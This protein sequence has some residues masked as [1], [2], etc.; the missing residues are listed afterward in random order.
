MESIQPSGSQVDDSSSETFRKAETSDPAMLAKREFQ[1][2]IIDKEMEE[3]VTDQLHTSISIYGKDGVFQTFEQ[4]FKEAHENPDWFALLHNS[5]SNALSA[6]YFACQLKPGDEVIFPVY[7]FHA[8]CSSAMHFGIRPVLADVAE[9]GNIS[10]LAVEKAI[11]PSTRAVVITHMWGIPVNMGALLKV[12]RRYPH[13]LLLEDCSHAHGARINGQL[14]GTFGD[15]AAWSLQGQKIL[16]GGEGGIVLTR[17]REIHIRGLLWGH[18]N[19]RCKLEIPEC[20]PLRS[21]IGTS[22][23]MKNRAHP[24]AVRIALDQLRK[25]PQFRYYKTLYAARLIAEIGKIPFL[26]APRFPN[27]GG[28]DNPSTSVEP[29]YYALTFRFK[30]HLAPDGL[31]RSVFVS[32]L[33]KRG[34]ADVDIPKSTGLLHQEPL[35]THPHILLPHVQFPPARADEPK[36]QHFPF[37]QAFYDELIKIPVWASEGDEGVVDHYIRVFKEVA[38]ECE[39]KCKAVATARAE[40][41]RETVMKTKMQR[42]PAGRSRCLSYDYACD[43]HQALNRTSAVSA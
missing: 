36:Q 11:T 26:E 17:H 39:E 43:Q 42:W 15:G 6:L 35:F 10:A 21:F 40:A 2:P 3:A 37:A 41:Q 9:N 20:H 38:E 19:K 1:W 24:L 31:T 16:T 5:G 23:G 28:F 30:R 29:A 32:L 18:Y 34:L 14:V 7:T 33:H 25:L 4:E 27:H 12:L 13:I 8:T 22:S